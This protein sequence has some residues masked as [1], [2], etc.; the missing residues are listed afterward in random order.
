MTNKFQIPNSKLRNILLAIDI[1]NTT[2]NFGI[3]RDRRLVKKSQVA[4]EKI[5]V[6][7]VRKAFP[8][9]LPS[10]RRGEGLD[11]ILCSVVPKATKKVQAIVKSVTGVK[12]L[13]LGKDIKAPIKNLYRKPRQ[14]GQDRLAD[15]V[16]AKHI[17]GAPVVVVDF[18][19][20]ITFDVVN[21][22]GAYAGGIIFP[23]LEL[24]LNTL[25]KRAALLPKIRLSEPKTLIGRDTVT[26][27]KSGVTYGIASLC[28][29]IISR[30]QAKYGRR[31]RVVATGGD[32]AFIARHTRSIKVVDKDLTLKGLRLIFT[33]KSGIA[34]K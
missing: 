17:Y 30:I 10:P 31:I 13:V 16:A 20:A 15:A 21:K 7:R 12:P 25:S 28:D 32:A 4:T 34:R 33:K 5:S 2:T 29:G 6:A 1:G 18:G 26:S 23:G 3:F 14:V 27:M 24:S 11:I 22:A 19:T 8:S 9:P